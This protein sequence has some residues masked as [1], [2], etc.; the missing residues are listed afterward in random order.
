ML[1]DIISYT[2]EQFAALTEEQILQIKEAQF[3]KNSLDRQM[4]EEKLKEKHRLLDNGTFRSQIWEQYRL[5]LQ[6]EYTDKVNVIREPLLFYLQFSVK[7]EDETAESTPY[8]VDYSLDMSTRYYTVRDYYMA[9]YTDVDERVAAFKADTVA[10]QYL[11]ELYATLYDY[12]LAQDRVQD[13]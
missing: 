1:I 10:R 2:N 5:A 3:K 9:A 12:L 6:K 8:P 13:A 11:G 4:E 7:P